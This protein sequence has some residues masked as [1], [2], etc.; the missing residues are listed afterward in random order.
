M[1]PKRKKKLTEFDYHEV[2]D[3]LSIVQDNLNDHILEHQIFKSSKN[4]EVKEILEK[5]GRLLFKAYQRI[6]EK[7]FAMIKPKS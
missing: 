7:R 6:G 1:A 5:A 3:R 4:E 2:L